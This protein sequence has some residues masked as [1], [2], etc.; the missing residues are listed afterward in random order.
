MKVWARLVLL[1]LSCILDMEFADLDAYR[2]VA[3]LKALNFLGAHS[4]YVSSHF[5]LVDTEKGGQSCFPEMSE[6]IFAVFLR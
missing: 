1:L 6:V 4:R 5:L 3:F 2:A